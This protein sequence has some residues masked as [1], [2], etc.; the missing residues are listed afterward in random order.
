[1]AKNTI[2][3]IFEKN[4]KN[5]SQQPSRNLWED[6]ENR[7]DKK[8]QKKAKVIWLSV[9]ASILLLL[10]TIVLWF[11]QTNLEKN[12]LHIAE[13]QKKIDK[14]KERNLD[15]KK[16]DL[17]QKTY[18]EEQVI[19]NLKV[20]TKSFDTHKKQNITKS[21]SKKTLKN[22]MPRKT[23]KDKVENKEFLKLNNFDETIANYTAIENEE[24]ELIVTVTVSLHSK[25]KEKIEILKPKK[26]SKVGKM[27]Q[28]VRK[29]KTGEET[30]SEE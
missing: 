17:I 20:T 10:T 22:I 29:A 1:M 21:K 27:W 3:K 4:L 7:L 9:A 14:N 12:S 6:I 15:K 30:A 19:D 2:D 23:V 18:S 8:S 16:K 5:H 11:G 28:K 26:P 13:E 24:E 25:P